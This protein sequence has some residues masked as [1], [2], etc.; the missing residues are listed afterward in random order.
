AGDTPDTT[1]DPAPL[2]GVAIGYYQ[3]VLNASAQ[4]SAP[5][6]AIGR[7]MSLVT[8]GSYGMVPFGALLMGWVI[9][10][11]S[12]RVAIAIGGVAC[13]A[14]SV[15]VAV[16]LGRPAAGGRRGPGPGPSG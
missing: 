13:L 14:C 3:G 8:L 10:L 15:F 5:P 4:S 11:S 2:L 12:G 7:L 1:G 9:D 6:Q 16:R